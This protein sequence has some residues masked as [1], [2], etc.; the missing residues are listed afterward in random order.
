[1]KRDATKI[2]RLSQ[3]SRGGQTLI[4][5]KQTSSLILIPAMFLSSHC[6]VFSLALVAA[7]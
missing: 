5:L 4:G 7:P 3:A 6:L 1:M 2:E